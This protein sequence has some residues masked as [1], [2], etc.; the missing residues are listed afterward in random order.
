MPAPFDCLLALLKVVGLVLDMCAP[1][2]KHLRCDYS[3]ML[4]G[5]V[6]YGEV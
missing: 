4:A 1:R 5:E 6:A 3:F 2:S